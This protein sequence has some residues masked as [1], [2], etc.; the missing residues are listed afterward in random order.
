MGSSPGFYDEI[1]VQ[2]N[3]KYQILSITE[4]AEKYSLFEVF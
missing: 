1:V 3:D 4:F 2:I